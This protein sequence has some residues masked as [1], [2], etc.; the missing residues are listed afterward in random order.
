[1]HT[2]LAALVEE[3]NLSFRTLLVEECVKPEGEVLHSAEKDRLERS[4]RSVTA[5]IIKDAV[6]PAC[7]IYH[8]CVYMHIQIT[9]S[10]PLVTLSDLDDRLAKC[11][12]EP[13]LNE[14]SLFVDDTEDS[15]K[16]AW[17][18]R[19]SGSQQVKR[20][21]QHCKRDKCHL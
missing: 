5:V 1:M 21:N 14:Q 18:S 16:C 13:D 10:P 9:D 2:A 6:V 8:L 17:C 11:Y 3:S 7:G 4:E 12:K 20:V 15:I 19:W